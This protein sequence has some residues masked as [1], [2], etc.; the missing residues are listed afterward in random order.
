MC[1]LEISS[2]CR[3]SSSSTFDLCVVDA[4]IFVFLLA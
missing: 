1:V 4:A 2:Q 3:T